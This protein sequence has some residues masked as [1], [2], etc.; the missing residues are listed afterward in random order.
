[1]FSRLEIAESTSP[2]G[3]VD[4]RA[5]RIPIHDELV[6]ALVSITRTPFQQSKRQQGGIRSVGNRSFIRLVVV[7]FLQ[8]GKGPRPRE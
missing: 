4:V 1:M 8:D 7:L 2:V 3:G 6:L 5:A